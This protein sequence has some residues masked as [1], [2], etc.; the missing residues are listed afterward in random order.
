MIDLLVVGAHPDDAELHAGGLMA[1]LS[2]KGAQVVL[3]DATAGELGTRGTAEERAAEAAEAARILGVRRVCLG[4]PD[5][6]V[7]ADMQLATRAVVTTIREHR[8]AFVL[9]H[10]PGDH[11]PDHSAVS[12]AVKRA[13][14]MANV[15][16]Y[17]TGQE[18]FAPC[19]LFYYWGHRHLPPPPNCFVTDISDHFEQKLA[20]L[21]AHRSQFH[22]P[23]YDAP[24]TFV[25]S[26]LFWRAVEARAAY[27]GTLGWVRYAEVFIPVDTLRLD[28]PL[29]AMGH[30]PGSPS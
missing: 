20:A 27:Y 6:S 5:G 14:F 29:E 11:H 25:S 8:P 1:K 9:T 28:D 13:F 19:K 18:R 12:E 26:E 2:G 16:R 30:P 10:A 23:D 15:L 24:R 22:N 7:G 3:A 21:R 17:E 4:L